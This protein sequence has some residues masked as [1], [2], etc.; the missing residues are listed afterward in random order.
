MSDRLGKLDN[1]SKEC[2]LESFSEGAVDEVYINQPKKNW[3]I[4]LIK[5]P[6]I[7]GINP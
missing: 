3:A 6:G 7:I 2:H 4:G 1:F 5:N